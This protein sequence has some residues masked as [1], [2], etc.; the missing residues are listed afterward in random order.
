MKFLHVDSAHNNVAI[1]RSLQGVWQSVV[2]VITMA[3]TRWFR[4]SGVGFS[5]SAKVF[6][7]CCTR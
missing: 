7:L 6:A 1:I 2:A 5:Q 4:F 3:E